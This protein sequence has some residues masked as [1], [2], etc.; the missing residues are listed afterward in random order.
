MD[1]TTEY[2]RADD[3]AVLSTQQ[4]VDNFLGEEQ[5]QARE[6]EE[7]YAEEPDNVGLRSSRTWAIS[8]RSRTRRTPVKE[9]GWKTPFELATGRRPQLGHLR[10]YGCQLAEF[11]SRMGS[12][13]VRPQANQN[14]RGGQMHGRYGQRSADNR[15]PNSPHALQGQP[16]LFL[17]K[18][19]SSAERR[20][21]PTELEVACL[22]WTVCHVRWMIEASEKPVTVITDHTS[23]TGIAR[24]TSLH[25]TSIDRQN[26]R[27]TRSS[28]YLS[29]FNLRI[30]HIP[31]RQHIVR[32]ALSR[33]LARQ[34]TIVRDEDDI[35]SSGRLQSSRGISTR[36]HA[37]MALSLSLLALRL[38]TV[39]ASYAC[40]P[41]QARPS[42]LSK[43]AIPNLLTALERRSVCSSLHWRIKYPGMP[44]SFPALHM[45]GMKCAKGLSKHQPFFSKNHQ[46]TITKTTCRKQQ[47]PLGLSSLSI[48]SGTRSCVFGTK[49]GPPAPEMMKNSRLSGRRLSPVPR[50]PAL[51]VFPPSL[52]PTSLMPGVS[53]WPPRRAVA[54][55]VQR[56]LI[57]EY[58]NKVLCLW[59]KIRPT[60]TRNDEELQTV[61]PTPVPGPPPACPH[62]P[63]SLRPTSLMS[64]VSGWPPRHAVARRV[65]RILSLEYFTAQPLTH[66]EVYMIPNFQA[67]W[68]TG[69]AH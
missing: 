24:Q 35:R 32:D 45:S 46:S 37:S 5:E 69:I 26:N 2:T 34:D 20:Y 62:G 52:R 25:S 9:K 18:T 27:L 50:L 31:G 12:G 44:I 41:R 38:K 14:H 28:Q 3:L 42:A 60:R 29:T 59:H 54:R 56:T 49:S 33:L 30:I 16:V 23:T 11:Y 53:G 47:P 48:P 36:L 51:L 1:S 6:L 66:P 65:Q 67:F 57:L 63:P 39:T 13:G 17:S 10:V 15:P 40:A 8:A 43:S 21:W 64:G 58:F 19:L 4:Y 55:R 68:S 61:W 7:L 22:I